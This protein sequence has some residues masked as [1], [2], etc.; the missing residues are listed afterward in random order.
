MSKELH[1]HICSESVFEGVYNK[2]AKDLHDFLYYKYGAESNPND[3]TQDAFVKLWD[4]CKNVSFSKA[5]SYL[6]TV[7][8]NMVLNAIKHKKVVLKFQQT[9][10]KS[11]TTETP[12]HVLEQ[13]EFLKRYQVA[14]SKLTE[15]QRVAFLMNKAEGKKHAE[16]AEFLGVTRKVVEYR[17]YT[18][19][20]K[21]KQELGDFKLK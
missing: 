8:N 1:E 17:I 12:E 6:F 3:I 16:I 7:A 15:D 21:L 19:F 14:L 4:N 11:S 9:K 5:K 20:D 10:P 2:Y 18:A 13:K